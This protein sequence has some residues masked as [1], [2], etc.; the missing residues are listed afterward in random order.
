MTPNAGRQPPRKT[1]RVA[2]TIPLA[3]NPILP[4]SFVGFHVS[5]CLP[6]T[7]DLSHLKSADDLGSIQLDEAASLIAFSRNDWLNN[8]LEAIAQRHRISLLPTQERP[9]VVSA[10]RS[11]DS[12]AAELRSLLQRLLQDRELLPAEARELADEAELQ[13]S[14][15]MRPATLQAALLAFKAA[16]ARD[17]E[18]EALET[19][20]CLLWCQ[21]HLAEHASAA[22]LQYLSVRSR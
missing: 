15:A 8:Q 1:P 2:D 9:A 22:G 17:E 19:L 5:A 18:G 20:L 11:L 4:M 7:L 14:L 16:T 3:V 13:R 12:H 6:S 10:G 21:L